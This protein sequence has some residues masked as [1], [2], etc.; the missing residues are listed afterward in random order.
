MMLA[1]Q[2]IRKTRKVNM[3]NTF[4]YNAFSTPSVKK[5]YKL[6]YPDKSVEYFYCDFEEFYKEKKRL[7][8]VWENDTNIKDRD[9]LV[10]QSYE[11]KAIDYLIKKREI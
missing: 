1:K 2:P 7:Q 9:N 8:R 10:W 3:V 5:Y 6:I 4:P 11:V